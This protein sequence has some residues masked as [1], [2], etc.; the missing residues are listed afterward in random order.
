MLVVTL[1]RLRSR[2]RERLDLS[3]LKD[4]LF[5]FAESYADLSPAIFVTTHFLRNPSPYGDS[6]EGF[7]ETY[8]KRKLS[9][10]FL[11]KV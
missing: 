7:K 2:A 3:S 4:K 10:K 6:I 8:I 5:S 11:I 9:Y 1:S